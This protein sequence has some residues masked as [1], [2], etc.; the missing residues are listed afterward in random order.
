VTLTTETLAAGGKNR[1]LAHSTGG[2]RVVVTAT[3]TSADVELVNLNVDETPQVTI[4]NAGAGAAETG[5]FAARHTGWTAFEV[6]GANPATSGGYTLTVMPTAAGTYLA[7]AGATPFVDAC[8][9]LGGAVVTMHADAGPFGSPD[10]EGLSNP[11]N[12]PAGFPYYGDNAGKFVI[13]TNG[14]LTFDTSIQL[15]EFANTA[16]PTASPPDAIVA[17]YWTDLANVQVCAKTGGGKI[18]VQWRGTQ[19]STGAVVATQAILT[20]ATGTIELVWDASQ[21]D[22]GGDATIGVE[23][24]AGAMATQLGFDEPAQITPGSSQLLTPQ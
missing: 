22:T 13:S 6:T 10:D 15:A 24:Y 2:D 3:P 23:D 4:N 8:T 17:P 12:V 20:A 5:T 7:A 16:L 14:F 9:G 18:V 1:Y 21:T 19:F 11:I